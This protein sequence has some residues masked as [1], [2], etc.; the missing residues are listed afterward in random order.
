MHLNS[1][2]FDNIDS[3]IRRVESISK[4]INENE[5]IREYIPDYRFYH[6]RLNED[7]P[8]YTELCEA[9]YFEELSAKCLC[10]YNFYKRIFYYKNALVKPCH[11]YDLAYYAYIHYKLKAVYKQLANV[12]AKIINGVSFSRIPSEELECNESIMSEWAIADV[13]FS[14]DARTACGIIAKCNIDSIHIAELKK[15]VIRKDNDGFIAYI[16]ENTVNTRHLQMACAL[17][18]LG[19][20][21]KRDLNAEDLPVNEMES[22]FNEILENPEIELP[23]NLSNFYKTLLHQPENLAMENFV[24]Y[25]FTLEILRV[26]MVQHLKH[27]STA[28]DAVVEFEKILQEHPEMDDTRLGY[29]DFK[30]GNIYLVR[31]PIL[32]DF[33]QRFVCETSY[34]PSV[35]KSKEPKS[36]YRYNEDRCKWQE[37]AILY[38][39]HRLVEYGFLEWSEDTLFSFMYRMCPEY[40]PE[41]SDPSPIVWNGDI[42]TLWTLIYHFHGESIKMD[43]L[44]RTFFLKNNGNTFTKYD[45]GKNSTHS[46]NLRIMKILQDPMFAKS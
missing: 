37:D 7:T 2:V 41:R 5:F 12:S 20:R 4:D 28:I 19:K 35:G 40:K 26:R 1:E 3:F 43:N 10:N 8:G 14:I 25:I 16:I 13:L 24:S 27:Y 11:I 36:C 34:P 39:Y 15:Y 30:N 38:L 29:D 23:T 44:T 18:L 9:E 33:K 17:I 6:E 42:S 31:F 46:K 32:E 21:I 22:S 45:G